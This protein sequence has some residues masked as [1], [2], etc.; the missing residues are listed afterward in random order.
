MVDTRC[1][2]TKKDEKPHMMK[3]AVRSLPPATL[4][5]MVAAAALMVVRMVALLLMVM[6]QP[7]RQQKQRQYRL[8]LE[9]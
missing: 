2:I 6:T 3:A 4:S 9:G 5:V 8:K 7:H 1:R